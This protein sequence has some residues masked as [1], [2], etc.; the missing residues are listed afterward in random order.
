VCCEIS[1][2]DRQVCHIFLINYASAEPKGYLQN[3]PSYTSCRKAK[4]WLSLSQACP[5]KECANFD[6]A[7][8]TQLNALNEWMVSFHTLCETQGTESSSNIKIRT[9]YTCNVQSGALKPYRDNGRNSYTWSRGLM[10]MFRTMQ[11]TITLIRF[12]LNEIRNTFSVS[13]WF[14]MDHSVC[15][16]NMNFNVKFLIQW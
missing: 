14:Y 11:S 2:V 8:L 9:Y 3:V 10:N 5:Y 7:S 6:I 16:H 13:V 15:Q 12:M 1:L 4:I